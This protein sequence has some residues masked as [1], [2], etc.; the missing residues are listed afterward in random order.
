MVKAHVEE[1][2]LLRNKVTQRLSN[3]F[4]QKK[5]TLAIVAKLEAHLTEA[6]VAQ[7]EVDRKPGA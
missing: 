4:H 2:G 5:Q 6:V 1:L 7:E 3:L